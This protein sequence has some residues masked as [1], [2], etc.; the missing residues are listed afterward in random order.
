MQFMTQK[1]L[2]DSN[3]EIESWDDESYSSDKDG[4]KED[5]DDDDIELNV[6]QW[7]QLHLLIWSLWL[8]HC[9]AVAYTM[10][11]KPTGIISFG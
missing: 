9:D 6:N 2:Q 5:S 8:K 10:E 7:Y 11:L 1:D 3:S 4:D